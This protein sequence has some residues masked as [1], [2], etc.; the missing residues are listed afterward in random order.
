MEGKSESVQLGCGTLILIALIVLIFSGGP[1]GDLERKVN[2]LE[3]EIEDLT[4]EVIVLQE[5]L[6]HM[7][8]LLE[9]E[10]EKEAGN[11]RNSEG[12]KTPR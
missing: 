2:D 6:D 11:E 10:Q 8:Q 3:K 7:T 1:V 5:K 4:D 9:E 12:L